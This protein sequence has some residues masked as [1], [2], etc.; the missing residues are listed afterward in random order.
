MKEART[1]T[2]SEV[3]HAAAFLKESS[4]LRIEQR[5]PVE[6][7][8]LIVGLDLREIG[9]DR[10]IE[11]Q[12]ASAWLAFADGKTDESLQLLRAAAGLD[13]T[14]DKH[15]VTPGE[16]LPARELLADMYMEMGKVGKAI[17]AY[18]ADLRSHPNRLN[19]LRGKEIAMR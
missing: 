2:G 10:E 11:R 7:H 13:D 15:P 6:V 5:K 9:V 19:G 12:V 4:P 17:A 18:D 8:L 16:V 1:T 14:T 3:E